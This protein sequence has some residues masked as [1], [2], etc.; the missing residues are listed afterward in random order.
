MD[1]ASPVSRSTMSRFPL[2]LRKVASVGSGW[3]KSALLVE[4]VLGTELGKGL[5]SRHQDLPAH[6]GV[7]AYQ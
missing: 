2:S 6:L 5:P 3:S 7:I 1:L 4:W